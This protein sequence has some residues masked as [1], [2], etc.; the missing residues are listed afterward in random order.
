MDKK[1][2]WKNKEAI[3]IN[4]EKTEEGEKL[5]RKEGKEEKVM[6]IGKKWMIERRERMWGK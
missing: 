2:N 6:M 3:Q 4:K 1:F 5:N